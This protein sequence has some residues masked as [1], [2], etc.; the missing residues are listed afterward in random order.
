M[1][2]AQNLEEMRPMLQW[3]VYHTGP[4]ESAHSF[5]SKHFR[6]FQFSKNTTN[7][8]KLPNYSSLAVLLAALLVVKT[9]Q[10]NGPD[11]AL[12]QG[13][14]MVRYFRMEKASA[15]IVRVGL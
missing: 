3:T 15:Q 1:R 10:G 4:L 14:V 12:T 6:Q 9:T 13:T 5:H 11:Y 8:Y 7:Q 2:R